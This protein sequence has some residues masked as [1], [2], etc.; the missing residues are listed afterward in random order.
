MLGKL[1]GVPKLG[2][3]SSTDSDCPFE[4]DYTVPP[5]PVTEGMQHI[6][7][8]EGVSRSLPSSPLLTHQAISM[9]LQPMKRL[10]G[11]AGSHSAAPGDQLQLLLLPAVN[12]APAVSMAMAGPMRLDWDRQEV[13]NRKCA[14]AGSYLAPQDRVCRPATEEGGELV[15]LSCSAQCGL[16]CEN[17]AHAGPLG[18][19]RRKLGGW[20]GLTEPAVPAFGKEDQPTAARLHTHST[21]TCREHF[22]RHAACLEDSGP[23]AA[24]GYAN[25]GAVALATRVHHSSVTSRE[26]GF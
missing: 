5:L 16:N 4:G 21:L 15:S 2:G 26:R 14:G 17:E 19:A 24:G 10:T 13:P 25:P 3:G 7:I 12:K 23:L 18:Y 8:M 22:N 1:M 11:A 20:G 6:R 9:R